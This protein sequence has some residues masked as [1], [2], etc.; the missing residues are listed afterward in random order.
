MTT[1]YFVIGL[2]AVAV[3]LRINI[4]R[5]TI[6]SLF[7]IL[8]DRMMKRHEEATLMFLAVLAWTLFITV[9]GAAFYFTAYSVIF[10]SSLT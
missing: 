2:I 8:I 4:L 6:V 9:A 7:F 1:A 3:V 5:V 10:L